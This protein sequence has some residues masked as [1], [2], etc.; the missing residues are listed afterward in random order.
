ME[1]SS[2]NII[3][4]MFY[5]GDESKYLGN[6]EFHNIVINMFNNNLAINFEFSCWRK[7][8]GN[9]EIEIKELATEK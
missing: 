7:Y 4:S 2:K 1:L 8:Y 9:G 6:V 5:L 3:D